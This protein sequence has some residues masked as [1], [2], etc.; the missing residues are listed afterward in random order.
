VRGACAP[1]RRSSWRQVAQPFRAGPWPIRSRRSTAGSSGAAFY[2]SML[3]HRL[4]AGGNIDPCGSALRATGAIH[5]RL[6]RLSGEQ[7]HR[8]QMLLHAGDMLLNES[9]IS[10]H[11]LTPMTDANS[12]IRVLRRND[13]ESRTRGLRGRRA[14]LPGDN[15]PLLAPARRCVASNRRCDLQRGSAVHR[16]QRPPT[17]RTSPRARA[18]LIVLAQGYR[19]RGCCGRLPKPPRCRTSPVACD[20][21]RPLLGGDE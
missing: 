17:C 2:S 3:D 4:H 10:N 11:P 5:H 1:C 13:A 12:E 21:L 7:A 19:D 18:W 6:P 8:Q 14:R 20:R 16:A 15:G 9:G